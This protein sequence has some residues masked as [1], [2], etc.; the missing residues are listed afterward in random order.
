MSIPLDV[1]TDTGIKRI[2]VDKKGTTVIS[3]S[4]V[5]IDPKTFY[6]KKVIME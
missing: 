2:T 6:L 3:Q 1:Q 5:I 4:Q